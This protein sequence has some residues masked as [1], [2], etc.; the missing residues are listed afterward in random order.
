MTTKE[1]VKGEPLTIQT[2]QRAITITFDDVHRYLCPKA[3]DAEIG[4]F[5]KVCQSQGL[6]PFARDCYLVK[7]TDDEPAAIIIAI[8]AFEKAAETCK[9]FKGYEAGVVLK[10]KP[11]QLEFR[12]GT[13]L[14]DD[15]KDQLA[16]GWAKVYRSD[17]D[18]PFY[19]AVN[20]SEY[21]KFTRSG[22][23]TRFWREMP[24]TMIRNVALRHALK[25][26]FPNRFA[27]LYTTAEIELPPEGELPPALEKDGKPY[28]KKLWA[29]VK[30]ELGLTP[31]QARELLHVDSIKKELIDAGW[32]AEKIW[33]ELVIAV[34][35]Q[36]A[37]EV[38]PAQGTEAAEEGIFEEK[39]GAVAP[40]EAE[41]QPG[42]AAPAKP[43]GV[44][45]APADSPRDVDIRMARG[46]ASKLKWDNNRLMKELKDRTQYTRF[47][48]TPDQELHDFASKLV[49][50]AECA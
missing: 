50:L 4:L 48:D 49:D 15:E 41:K 34:R 29:R 31:E 10:Q 36:K 45:A 22:Q 9:E 17:R 27:G 3:S 30:K 14:M 24:A 5:L 38:K 39:A 40:V 25:E 6:N 8:D 1:L 13:L 18:K 20:L 7:Y 35:L 16:G 47:E 2:E 44:S 11:G 28:W 43:K 32:T 12:E 46:A 19:A 33:D 42:T 21:R 37:T 23:V 26:A